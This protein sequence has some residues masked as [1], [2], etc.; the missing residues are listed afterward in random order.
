MGR[1]GPA[2]DAAAAEAFKSTLKV[3]FVHRHRSTT[4]ADARIKISTWIADF[5][6]TTRRHT[7]KRARPDHL[8][9]ADGRSTE[10]IDRPA[11]G[12]GG[13]TPSPGVLKRW[14]TLLVTV[15]M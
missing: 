15:V 10:N 5:Y 12:R 1:V 6:N 3:E 4:S 14:R 9:A 8:R 2:L 11:Q 13:V 7:A